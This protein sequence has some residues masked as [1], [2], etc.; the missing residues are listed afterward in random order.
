MYV[1][2]A[3]VPGSDASYSFTLNL[4]SYLEIRDTWL[5]FGIIL[6]VI[7]LIMI[8]ILIFL[9]NRIRIAIALIKEGSRAVSNMMF[10]LLWPLVPYI[11]MLGVMVLW[12]F[13]AVY[14]ATAGEAKYMVANVPSDY[15]GTSFT[16][17]SECL[18]NEFENRNTTAICVFVEYG[19][20]PNL[21]R[22]QIYILFG[23]FWMMCFCVALGQIVLAGAFASYY[24]AFHKPKDVPMFPV[25]ASLWRALRYHL[26]SL[27]FG[28]LIIAIVKMIRVILEYIEE[29]VK[30]AQNQAAKFLIKCLKCCFWCL[31]K[32]LKFINKNAYI[33]IAVYGKNFC[34]SAKK[35]FFL[36]MRNIVRVVVLDKITDFLLFVG[37]MCVV[38]GVGVGAFYFFT[39]KIDWFNNLVTVPNL[40]YYWVPIIVIIVGTYFISSAFFSVYSMGVDT[41][42]LCFLEDTER[43][44][45]SAE[46][47]YYM[48]KELRNILHKKN[49]KVED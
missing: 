39:G 16:N 6:T 22:M 46:K 9:C 1:D 41:L 38:L 32:C 20:D 28:S 24:W 30:S 48:N 45:G 2:M 44:D 12:C 17:G 23:L 5:A 10:T 26:G 4:K 37:K 36:L 8:L 13:I 11:M 3:N 27:A 49:K 25:S 29:K 21:F 15:A 40:N 18:P 42:F 34:T 19:G 43:H 47:P 35:A 31:E 7:T 33:M 14:L